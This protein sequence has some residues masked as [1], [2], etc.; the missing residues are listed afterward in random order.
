MYSPEQATICLV[1]LPNTVLKWLETY[2]FPKE[3]CFKDIAYAE[4]NYTK[5]V[6]KS[7]SCGV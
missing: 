6:K 3:S 7:L 4:T 5:C 2:T 1:L